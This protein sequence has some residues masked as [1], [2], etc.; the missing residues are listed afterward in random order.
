MLTP[1]DR[2]AALLRR[3]PGTTV[4]VGRRLLCALLDALQD[5]YAVRDVAESRLAAA[6]EDAALSRHL[7][8]L[9]G[10]EVDVARHHLVASLR[11]RE[12]LAQELEALTRAVNDREGALASV[13]PERVRAYL[14]AAGWACVAHSAY[15]E[16]WERGAGVVDLPAQLSPPGSTRVRW[17]L[18]LDAVAAVEGR[19]PTMVLAAWLV[20]GGEGGA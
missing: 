4:P 5:A 6:A 18:V 3:S 12:S 13:R 20:V 1:A 19:H 17:C 2:L 15:V 14:A 7:C 11:D 8:E 9:R 10:G 16:R